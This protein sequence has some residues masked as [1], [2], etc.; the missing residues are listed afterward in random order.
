MTNLEL[1]DYYLAEELQVFDESLP[2][3]TEHAVLLDAFVMIEGLSLRESK[4]KE[5]KCSR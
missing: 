4:W 2:D 1:I 3:I 5:Q